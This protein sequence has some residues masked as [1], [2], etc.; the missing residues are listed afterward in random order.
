MIS[1]YSNTLGQEEVEAVRNVLESRWLG[2]GKECLNFEKELAEKWCVDDVLLTNNCTSAIYIA[3]RTL[4]I[5]GG[6]VIISSI[7]FVACANAVIEL[8]ATPIFADVD[9]DTLNILP[10]EIERLKT[11]KTKAVIILHYGGHPARF[12]EIK[13]ACENI[14]IIEDSANSVMSLYKGRY[15]GTLDYAGVFSFDAMK[16]LV[17]GDGGALI[18]KDTETAKSLRYL[19]FAT[20]TTSGTDSVGQ[21]NRKWWEFNIAQPSGRF[22]SNDILASMGRIQLKKVDGFI[23]KRKKIWDIYQKELKGVALPPDPYPETTSSYYMYWIKT[24]KRDK[25]AEY[26]FDNDIYTTYR[27]YPLHLVFGGESLKN[28]EKINKTTLN[29]PLHQNLSDIDIEKIIDKIK[30]FK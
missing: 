26:L 13:A 7:N 14:P 23:K 21:G 9:E 18:I 6:E 11:D 17:M 19:G 27:Y 28:A 4:D 30:R 25:L 3:L 24:D 10:S 29:I 16:I 8:G 12:D 22:I 20:G 1:L 5:E 15:C 2:K